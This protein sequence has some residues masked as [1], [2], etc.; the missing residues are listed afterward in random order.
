MNIIMGSAPLVLTVWIFLVLVIISLLNEW[1][2][3]HSEHGDR[4]S[5]GNVSATTL[6]ALAIVSHHGFRNPRHSFPGDPHP[7]NN[8]TEWPEGRG[9]LNQIGRQQMRDMGSWI[10]D[11]Y[12]DFFPGVGIKDV[13]LLSNSDKRAIQSARELLSAVLS[14]KKKD[15]K[16]EIDEVMLSK[17]VEVAKS[18]AAMQ[19]I[20]ERIESETEDRLASHKEFIEMIISLT[21]IDKTGIFASNRIADLLRDFAMANKSMPHWATPEIRQHLSVI[22][23]QSSC[24]LY[25]SSK[26][27][28]L[29]T[30]PIVW[31]INHRFEDILSH[32]SGSK[33]LVYSTRQERM[34]L[35]MRSLG[36]NLTDLHVPHAA[37]IVFEMHQKDNSPTP[38][39]VGYFV[40]DINSSVRYLTPGKC[41]NA[42]IPYPFDDYFANV[43]VLD[44]QRFNQVCNEKLGP[45]EIQLHNVDQCFASTQ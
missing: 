5:T 13:V 11:R 29:T 41:P 20:L 39:V 42:H 32:G 35:L 8:L 43:E 10:R 25:T 4:G 16:P 6:R 24:V 1:V 3:V 17:V 44:R 27:V 2:H 31:D 36:V 33:L 14:R 22:K 15:F 30:A 45:H 19:P 26:L 40:R 23:K 21:G 37:S 9:K 38:H 18:C 7:F 34:S 12:P 28:S